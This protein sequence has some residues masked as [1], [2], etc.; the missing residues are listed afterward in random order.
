[1]KLFNIAIALSLLLPIPIAEAG[2]DTPMISDFTSKYPDSEF[3]KY[4]EAQAKVVKRLYTKEGADFSHIATL[5]ATVTVD[6]AMT[7]VLLG[8]DKKG[9]L[10]GHAQMSIDKFLELFPGLPM[11]KNKGTRS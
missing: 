6:D 4:T 10:V 7:E 8:F 11:A 2:C 3:I 9:C 5:Y 1:M